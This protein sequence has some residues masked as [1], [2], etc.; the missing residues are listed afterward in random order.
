MHAAWCHLNFLETFISRMDILYL[1]YFLVGSRWDV[2][3]RLRWL[4]LQLVREWVPLSL[5]QHLP[6]P[7][8]FQADLWRVR[9]TILRLVLSEESAQSLIEFIK[10][11]FSVLRLQRALTLKRSGS[12]P[13][14][15][16]RP[17][18]GTVALSQ[19]FALLIQNCESGLGTQTPSF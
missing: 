2:Y 8:R 18:D 9:F 7:V 14:Y 15:Q 4:I 11:V 19:F 12:I 1:F 17:T 3:P 6:C 16:I 5:P 13:P 10:Y